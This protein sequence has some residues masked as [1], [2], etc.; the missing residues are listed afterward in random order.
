[1]K[2]IG[3]IGAG[4]AGLT[5]AQKLHA[6][7]FNV[8]LL[9][10]SRGVGGRTATRRMDAGVTFDHGAQ[11]FTAR[12]SMFVSQVDQ[13]CAAGVVEPWR[14]RIVA[15]DRGEVRELHDQPSRYVGTPGMN[16]MAKSLAEGL[17]VLT[18]ITAT[19]IRHS[20]DQWQ[21][22]DTEGKLH[23]DFDAVIFTAPPKQTRVLLG[24]A[25]P[26][27][28]ES[29]SRVA[30]DCCWAIMLRLHEPLPVDFDGAFVDN[31]ALRW[32]ALNS[33]KPRRGN[34][35]CW[36]LHASSAWSADHLEETPEQ[37]A[38]LLLDHFWQANNLTPQPIEMMVAHRWL[39]SGPKAP[40]SER[41]LF[42][43]SLNLGACGDWCGG[44]RVEG[45]F[46]SGLAL[47]DAVFEHT[48]NC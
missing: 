18:Q 10:K 39:Y 44:P 17:N 7:G 30:M 9:E 40:L 2:N 26:V 28:Q 33:G 32:I 16:S 37:V 23:G 47:A 48:S 19:T 12:D 20:H 34:S 46:L 11:Y 22:E 43:R 13:W 38:E 42:D 6:H 8:T 25:S 15:L 41:Y 35:N 21:V 4:I 24:D 14:G 1:M 36:V 3:I 45:A 31:S 29:I 5:C 27:L